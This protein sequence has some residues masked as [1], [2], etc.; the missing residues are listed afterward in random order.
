MPKEKT[1]KEAL[2]EKP[3]KLK[4]GLDPKEPETVPDPPADEPV[5][6]DKPV[7]HA[8]KRKTD[9]KF[10]E[11]GSAPYV[12]ATEPLRWAA[13]RVGSHGCT[14]VVH[15]SQER[16]GAYFANK[17]G[18]VLDVVT[19]DRLE[20]AAWFCRKGGNCVGSKGA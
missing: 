18:E 11:L 12:L 9:V 13:L 3:L 20:P 2:A 1:L 17:V 4:D 8:D 10:D 16:E 6:T 19:D 14:L 5:P 15:P 7:E